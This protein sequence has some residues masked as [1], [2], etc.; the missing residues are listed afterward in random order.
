[1]QVT[2]RWHLILIKD[3]KK[4]KEKMGY[5]RTVILILYT[6]ILIFFSGWLVVNHYTITTCQVP[7][8]LES[9]K[10][11]F[12]TVN[13]IYVKFYHTAKYICACGI[14]RVVHDLYDTN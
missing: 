13:I 1:M 5:S 4:L 3:P 8:T 7:W 11:V 14:H 10:T 9:T 2:L 6:C 12:E